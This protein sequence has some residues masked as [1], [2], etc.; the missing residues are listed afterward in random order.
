MPRAISEIM[1]PE[2]FHV[3]PD[4]VVDTVLD[5]LDALDIGAAPVIDER[6]RPI[7]VISLRDCVFREGITV[8]Q[9]MSRPPIC[10]RS[11]V[12]IELAARI[13]AESGVHRLVVVD[14]NG[15]AVGMVSSSDVLRG[16]L[17]LPARHPGA[18]PH[19]DRATGLTWTDDIPFEIDHVEAAP[20]GAGVILLSHGGPG[21]PETIV[22]LEGAR[23]LRARLLDMLLLPQE[24]PELTHLLA[25]GHL[26]FRVAEV[27]DPDERARLVRGPIQA[28]HPGAPI[29]LVT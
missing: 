3:R 6:G 23:D 5:D 11:S 15:H 2:L 8:A 13:L 9:R 22:W 1:N 12:P 14:D 17:G 24:R 19:F 10:V 4:E 29:G 20:E 16:L 7:G 26:R 27:P 25:R 21:I 18:F 28:A